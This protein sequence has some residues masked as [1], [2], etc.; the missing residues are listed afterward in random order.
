LPVAGSAL[1]T[2]AVVPDTTLTTGAV[3]AGSGRLAE[4]EMVGPVVTVIPATETVGSLTGTGLEIATTVVPLAGAEDVAVW[5]AAVVVAADVRAVLLD[6]LEVAGGADAGAGAAEVV[7]ATV[8][9]VAVVVRELTDV[10]WVVV[11][12]AG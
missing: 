9:D 12:G 10:V 11:G 3:T 2:A 5:A 6:V 8:V 1:V 4:T 7:E